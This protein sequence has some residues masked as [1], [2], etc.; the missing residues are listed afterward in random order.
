MPSVLYTPLIMLRHTNKGS[1]P[2]IPP[3][4]TRPT[5]TIPTQNERNSNCISPGKHPKQNSSLTAPPSSSRKKPGR[6]RRLFSRSTSSET[7]QSNSP[8]E[9]LLNSSIKA[10]LLSGEIK[11]I[12][13]EI[14][15]I[16]PKLHPY[17]KRFTLNPP[18]QYPL[19]NELF[20]TFLE[21]HSEELTAL[22][23]EINNKESS[24]ETIW[25]KI[26][27]SLWDKLQKDLPKLYNITVT[28]LKRAKDASKDE[29][30][31]AIYTYFFTD[32]LV[33]FNQLG[34]PSEIK[35]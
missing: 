26:T 21:S 9:D 6:I 33:E 20:M 4:D 35:T 3:T 2:M 32:A 5:P 8:L 15:Y 25:V 22:Y 23:N 28:D 14:S 30:T 12:D 10:A 31:K 24:T 11:Y 19:L 16:S 13:E 27:I 18:C 34:E 29:L 1:D 17:I 7:G